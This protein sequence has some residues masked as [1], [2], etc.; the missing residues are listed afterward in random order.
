MR[1]RRA[2]GPPRRA[3]LRFSFR[4]DLLHRNAHHAY[5]ATPLALPLVG[6][7][8]ADAGTSGTSP[9]CRSTARPI[10]QANRNRG[11]PSPSAMKFRCCARGSHQPQ[12]VEHVMQ[13]LDQ[14]AVLE[15]LGFLDQQQNLAHRLP[16]QRRELRRPDRSSFCRRPLQCVLAPPCMCQTPLQPELATRTPGNL[17]SSVLGQLAAAP[18][19]DRESTR[20]TEGGSLSL[21]LPDNLER[22]RMDTERSNS[23]YNQASE[24][25]TTFVC[26]VIPQH[27]S[28]EMAELAGGGCTEN[29]AAY[30]PRFVPAVRRSALRSPSAVPPENAPDAGPATS[31]AP[32][33]PCEVGPGP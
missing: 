32:T 1:T 16:P 30:T 5:M 33:P 21:F 25:R 4:G 27:R 23:K 14:L 26:R 17:W 8:R 9:D 28:P 10:R 12:P 29:H 31:P 15:T 18:F 19:S 6:Q 2:R 7:H 20:A 24:Q 22:Y 3:T 13:I 11:T